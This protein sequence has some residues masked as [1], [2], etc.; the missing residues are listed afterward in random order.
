MEN[1][2]IIIAVLVTLNV[3]SNVINILVFNRRSTEIK[4]IVKTHGDIN[5]EIG[6]KIVGTIETINDRTT[7]KTITK[8]NEIFLTYRDN[9]L[10]LLKTSEKFL[11]TLNSNIIDIGKT[12]A[13]MNIEIMKL[14]RESNEKLQQTFMDHHKENSI[15]MQNKLNEI[16][17]IMKKGLS[18]IDST[19]KETINIE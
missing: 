1:L 19:L 12:T 5:L 11:N 6:N 4:S 13:E 17:D 15:L 7:D 3:I 10:L 18:N 2:G 8:L 9:S 16:A 14:L